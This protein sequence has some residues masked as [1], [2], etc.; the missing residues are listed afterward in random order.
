MSETISI[1][2]GRTYR[3]TGGIGVL[4]RVDRIEGQ[5][6]H[7]TL[8]RSGRSKEISL[9]TLRTAYLLDQGAK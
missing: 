1:E 9:K 3:G 7:C 6:A 4:V 8:L 5:V 2:V